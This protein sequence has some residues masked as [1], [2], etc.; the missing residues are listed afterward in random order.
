MEAQRQEERF[1]V[2]RPVTQEVDGE[3][4]VL[5]VRQFTVR[6]LLRREGAY[7]VVVQLAIR[8]RT[9]LTSDRK[10]ALL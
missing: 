3:V 5:D 9:Y 8:A 2:H 6:D 10:E 4:S 7:G 1:L